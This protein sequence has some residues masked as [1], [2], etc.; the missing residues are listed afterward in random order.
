MNKPQIVEHITHSVDYSVF[1]VKWVPNTAK[2]VIIG[3]KSTGAGILQVMEMNEN[4]LDVV[5]TIERNK[6]LK[7]CS[8]GASGIGSKNV[9]IGDFI[10]SFSVL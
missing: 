8:F 1:D 5:A 3:A 6:S 7:C 9:A 2:F 4:N 10:G